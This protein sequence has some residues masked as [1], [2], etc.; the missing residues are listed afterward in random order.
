M[1]FRSLIL[2]TYIS[3]LYII[4]I[5]INNKNMALPYYLLVVLLAVV[6]NNPSSSSGSST[7][8]EAVTNLI[9]CD[10]LLKYVFAGAPPKWKL[11]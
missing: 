10:N 6:I 1:L 9:N 11:F 5:M 4:I 7:P 8:L 2:P 3:L